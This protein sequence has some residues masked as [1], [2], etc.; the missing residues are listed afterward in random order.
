MQNDV[1][2]TGGKIVLVNLDD[3]CKLSRQED[4]GI[5]IQTG[6]YVIVTGRAKPLAGQVW[7]EAP[8]CPDYGLDPTVVVKTQDFQDNVIGIPCYN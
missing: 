5:F 4:Y 6:D 2:L 1:T 3:K 8:S 7:W